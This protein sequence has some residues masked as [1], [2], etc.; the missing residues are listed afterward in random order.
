MQKHFSPEE[1]KQSFLNEFE[2]TVESKSWLAVTWTFNGLDENTNPKF[3]VRK[4]SSNFN[5][6]HYL[7]ALFSL[8]GLLDQEIESQLI[9][10]NQMPLPL[11]PHLRAVDMGEL[12]EVDDESIKTFQEKALEKG[13]FPSILNKDKSNNKEEKK[14]NESKSDEGDTEL[15]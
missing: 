4:T 11:A 13:E 1:S 8:K 7:A 6:S 3:T 14:S 9:R 12:P 5:M 10:Q 2:K 15:D